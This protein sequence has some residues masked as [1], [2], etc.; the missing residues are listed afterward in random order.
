[1]LMRLL[2]SVAFFE[3]TRTLFSS[4][5]SLFEI[6]I[7]MLAAYLVYEDHCF[8]AIYAGLVPIF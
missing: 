8:H 5:G 6:V 7:S 3:H 4:L 1:M 2:K